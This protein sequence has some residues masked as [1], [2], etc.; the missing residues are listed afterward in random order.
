VRKNLNTQEVGQV[1]KVFERKSFG[2]TGN[3]LGENS[4]IATCDN[5]VI[6]VP[7]KYKT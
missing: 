5:Y 4:I 2:K 7:N 1:T 3:K 6:D